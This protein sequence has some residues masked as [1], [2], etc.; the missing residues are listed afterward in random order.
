MK[1]I[2]GGAYQG[3]LDYARVQFGLTDAE[4]CDCSETEA[5]DFSKRCLNHIERYVR[6][7]LRSGQE[8]CEALAAWMEAQPEGILICEDIFCGVVPTDAEL[9][10]WREACGRFLSRAAGQAEHVVRL[11]CG[12]PQV[13]K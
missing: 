13:L 4:I 6:H 7:C 10:A 12:L 2:I 1:L 5:P 3:K 11:F 8:P 9:R